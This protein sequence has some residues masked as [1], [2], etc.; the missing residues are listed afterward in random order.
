MA[1]FE[2][3][4]LRHG[5]SEKIV[6]PTDAL[7]VQRHHPVQIAGQG[8]V[9]CAEVLKPIEP[10]FE[11]PYNPIRIT[12]CESRLPR[13]HPL[14]VPTQTHLPSLSIAAFDQKDGRHSGQNYCTRP[15]ASSLQCPQDSTRL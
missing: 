7:F 12:C 10:P 3:E 2:A 1:V 11:R 13:D 8:C 9:R 15:V 5:I 6:R 4:I 14:P